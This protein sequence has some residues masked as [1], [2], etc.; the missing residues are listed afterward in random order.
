MNELRFSW[1]QLKNRSNM[2]KHGVS[3]EEA[4]ASF[5]DENALLIPDPDHSK[6]EERFILLGIGSKLRLLVVIHTY[7]NDDAEIRIIS[8]R[9]ATKREHTFYRSKVQ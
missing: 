6:E 4:Q 8:A 1:D 2:T 7:R 9:K 3:F 5:L